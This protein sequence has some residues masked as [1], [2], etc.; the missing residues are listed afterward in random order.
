MAMVA[1]A[2]AA[3]PRP[4]DLAPF[5]AGTA[6]ADDASLPTGGSWSAL[7]TDTALTPDDA[8]T[9]C[10]HVGSTPW[11]M[12]R[13]TGAVCFG[14]TFTTHGD[15]AEF[16]LATVPSETDAAWAGGPRP[17]SISARTPRSAAD[18]APA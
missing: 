11:E 10:L 8:P 14:Q 5:D 9:S 4:G 18:R 7:P 12:L 3:P 6:A 15:P 2:C 16:A 13:A 1:A 17:P